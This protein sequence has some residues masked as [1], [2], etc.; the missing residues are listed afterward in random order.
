MSQTG[1]YSSGGG[2]GGSITQITTNAGIAVP[3]GGNVNVFGGHDI[4]TSG[5]GDTVII[6]LNNA[7]TLGDVTPLAAF[8]NALEA[9]TGDVTVDSGNINLPATTATDGSVGVLFLGGANFLHAFGSSSNTFVGTISGN[10][11]LDTGNALNNT[12]VGFRTLFSLTEGQ[13]NVAVGLNALT[14]LT[15]GNSNIGVGNSAGNN[16]DSGTRNI[17]IGVTAGTSYTAAESNNIIIGNDGTATESNVIRIGTQ[18]A[19][20]GQ[21]NTCFI[22]G[23]TGVTTSNSALVTIDTTTGQLGE[24]P[25]NVAF[26]YT[27]VNTTPYV[28]TATDYYLSVDCSGGAITVQLPNAPTNFRTFVVK[29]R[30]GNAGANNITVT[31]VGGAVNI[32]GAATFVMN[33][34]FEAIQLIFNGTT[35]EI[36]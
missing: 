31:T 18:G 17:M 23:I 35:Y 5:A 34:N 3:V 29:D 10:F 15:T 24:T 22:A 12:G 27:N 8:T 11:T 32:D 16:L 9:V 4:N 14:N 28:V 7:I 13:S 2:G 21:Q 20:A 25:L 6:N 19:G 30:T 33:T 1:R 26:S 36:Y